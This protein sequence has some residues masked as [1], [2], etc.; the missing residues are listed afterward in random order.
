ML[1]TLLNQEKTA[2]PAPLAGHKV[3]EI[4]LCL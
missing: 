2:L 1:T 3:A 4:R